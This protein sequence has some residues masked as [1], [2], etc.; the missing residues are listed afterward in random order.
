MSSLGDYSVG[1]IGNIGSGNFGG[2]LDGNGSGM[3]GL[4]P[5]S[6]IGGRGTAIVPGLGHGSPQHHLLQQQQ[7]Q[8]LQMPFDRPMGF[9]GNSMLESAAADFYANHRG[10]GIPPPPVPPRLHPGL[11]INLASQQQQQQQQGFSQPPPPLVLSP[12]SILRKQVRSI[13]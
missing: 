9:A 12:S 13:S 2:D 8:Q 11:G 3:F 4:L 6:P 1:N 7:Q 5:S 10:T